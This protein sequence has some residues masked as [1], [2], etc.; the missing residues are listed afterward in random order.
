MLESFSTAEAWQ[1]LLGL[2]VV[3]A[4]AAM[5]QGRASRRRL[6]EQAA[7]WAAQ[8]RQAIKLMS[9]EQ[10][11][12]ECPAPVSC[13]VTGGN[14]MVGRRVMELLL[15]RGAK[16][17]VCFDVVPT[18]RELHLEAVPGSTVEYIVGDI[19]DPAALLRACEGVDVVFHIAALVGP[20]YAHAAYIKVNYEGTLNVI[21]ACRQCGVRKLVDCPSPSTRFPG[22]D[23]GGDITGQTEVE[24][25]YPTHFSHEYARTKALGERAVLDAAMAAPGTTT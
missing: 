7:A 22:G 3:A 5:I 14:G 20:F 19:C 23:F 15:E 13:L 6:A 12:A 11:K 1:L 24:L 17:V 18:P 9:K 25:P 16:R 10:A 21:A 2:G 4:A 8:D